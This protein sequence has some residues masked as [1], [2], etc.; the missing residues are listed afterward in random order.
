MESLNEQVTT[1]GKAAGCRSKI[2]LSAA[3]GNKGLPP[4][5]GTFSITGHPC[6]GVVVRM[7]YLALQII[8]INPFS[9]EIAVSHFQ[10]AIGFLAP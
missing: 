6:H 5:V 4:A 1:R 8:D 9:I 2:V 3:T 7:K 10:I